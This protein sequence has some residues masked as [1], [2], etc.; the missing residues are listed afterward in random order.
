M[1]TDRTEH[2]LNIIFPEK[3]LLPGSDGIIVPSGSTGQRPS[4]PDPGTVRYNTT[5][6][7]LE[8]Y[9]GAPANTWETIAGGNSAVKTASNV[10]VG[11]GIFKQKTGFDLE[12]KSI[13]AGANINVIDTGNEVQIS[14]SGGVG[15]ANTASNV[16]SGIG[17]FL[18]KSGT[19][20]QFRSLNSLS[21]GLNITN[22]G[23]TVDF[24][25]VGSP[26]LSLAGG[27][28]TGSITMNPGSSV[29]GSSGQTAAVPAFNFTADFNSGIYSA[30]INT[31]G[32]STNGTEKLRIAPNG[33]LVVPNG[34]EGFVTS[35]NIIPNKKYVDDAIIAL[36]S[37]AVFRQTFTDL[38]LIS[39]VVQFAHNLGQNFTQI[40]LY[41]NFNKVIIPG[42]IVS[43]DTNTVSVDLKTFGMLV[44]NWNVVIIG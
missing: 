43:L 44:G 10:G 37:V 4:P 20:L 39:G 33:S 13:L 27:T 3:V 24:D 32:F 5:N 14:T 23:A 19:D 7:E 17:T 35:D 36:S 28:M 12:F 6:A 29:H 11:T 21:A 30:G 1:F 16:G 22:G 9:I 26:F 8:V 42:E 15:E 38:N 34:Y 25:L 2:W 41:D 18:A 40:T 31:I